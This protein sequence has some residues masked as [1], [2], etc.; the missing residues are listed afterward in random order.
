[1]RLLP[2]WFLLFGGAISLRAQFIVPDRPYHC[3][4][5]V[6]ACKGFPDHEQRV[7]KAGHTFDINYV[8]YNDQGKPWNPVELEDAVDEIKA[9]IGADHSGQALVIV[10][11][12]GWQN[13]AD[14]PPDCEDVCSFRD[15]LLPS[16]A[17]AQARSGHPL[18]VLGI[19]LG[20]R[21]LTFTK[22]P[23]KHGIT[24]WH[25]R[26]IARRDGEDGMYDAISAIEQAVRPYRSHYVLVLAGHSFGSR[27]LENAV[28]TAHHGREGL[29]LQYREAR[30]SLLATKAG[31]KLRTL[32]SEQKEYLLNPQLPAD[33]ILYINAATS[34]RVTRRTLKDIRELCKQGSD[35][36]CEADPLYVAVT[37]RADWATGTLMPIANFLGP[38]ISA[39]RYWLRSAANSPSLHTHEV[40][41]SCNST[42]DLLCFNVL[43]HQPPSQ[44]GIAAI[45]GRG[46]VAGKQ[47]HPFWI[48][49]VGGEVMDSHVDVW[50]PTV[51]DLVTSIITRHPKFEALSKAAP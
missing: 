13:N 21:G 35:P 4:T 14:E 51:T 16:L 37:S 11:I 1:M 18:R 27:V 28:D 23:F 39:D 45:P 26:T 10:Y 20:W 48:F 50:N 49:N 5:S 19:Y 25:R 29:M 43:S 44:E 8:E 30:K 46:Q 38:D 40:H 36:L 7:S 24:Y 2:L 42:N 22:E 17:D 34:S 33:L 47:N 41:S 6:P 9:T 3:P 12:H 32:T 31:G 15:T